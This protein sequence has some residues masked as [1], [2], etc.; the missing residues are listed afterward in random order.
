MIKDINDGYKLNNGVAI[1]CLGYGT[2]RSPDDGVTVDAVAAAIKAGYR[3]IDCAPI[4]NNEVSVGQGIKKGMDLCGISR[5]DLFITS[6][7]W[8]AFR[9]YDDAIRTFNDSLDELGLEYLDLYLIHWP[10][11]RD[12]F[13]N[14]YARMNGE[15]W[16][17]FETL[18]GEGK[19]KSIGVS[20]FLPHHIKALLGGCKIR[21]SVKQIE[22]HIGYAQAE[23][24]DLCN[25]EG[26]LTEAYSPLGVG[27]LLGDEKITEAAQ[28]YKKT[29]AQICI[30]WCMQ[31]GVV[32]LPK[33]VTPARIIENADVFDFEISASD[34]NILNA[35]PNYLNLGSNPDALMNETSYFVVRRKDRK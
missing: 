34:M 13:P 16:R 22:Y 33:S 9:K 14:D 8:N 15:S 28:K 2:W 31:N 3:L 5:K 25:K 26:I 7:M 10:A 30:R 1:P 24:V 29:A 17:A 11:P 20:N 32:P 12:F 27:A 21:P 19:I 23:T 35:V 18:Y 6:K 4:Y